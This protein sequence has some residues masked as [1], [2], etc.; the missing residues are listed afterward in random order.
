M[1]DN[2]ISYQAYQGMAAH[3]AGELNQNIFNAMYERPAMVAMLPDVANLKILDAGC[4][5]GFLSKWLVE[6][7]CSQVT[8]IDFSENMIAHSKQLCAGEAFDFR[9]WDLNEKL[10]FAENDS[11]D[12]IVSSLT[13]HYLEDLL[14]VM[15]EFNRVLKPGGLLI[16]S[17]HHPTMTYLGHELEDYFEAKLLTGHWNKGG[18]VYDVSFYHRSLHA[19]VQPL[20][21]AGFIIEDMQEPMPLAEVKEIDP[22]EYR[23]L[24]TEPRF[25]FI[26]AKKMES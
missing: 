4:G 3:Y 25:L 10:D 2:R 22:G 15:K 13:I 26:R 12:C 11:F 20:F 24:S 21:Q 16:F 1:E 18:V 7:G 5:A 17:T 9:V 6:Q 14:A 19:V 8:G 23:L